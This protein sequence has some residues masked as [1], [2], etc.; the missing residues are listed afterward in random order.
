M[1]LTFDY[2]EGFDVS[3]ERLVRLIRLNAPANIICNELRILH[4]RAS[5]CFAG[6]YEKEMQDEDLAEL[7]EITKR[8]F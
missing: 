2:R 4:S 8:A 1:S 6:T 3:A 7:M 5:V